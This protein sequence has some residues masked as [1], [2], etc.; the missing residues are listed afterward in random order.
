[1]AR[2]DEARWIQQAKGL[3]NSGL[4]GT[5]D[6]PPFAVS[7][8]TYFYGANSA[9]VR[10]YM[11]RTEQIYK[12]KAS[13]PTHQLFLHARGTVSNTVREL[14]NNLVGNIRATIEGDYLV[15]WSD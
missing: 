8:L 9:Q 13:G 5:H 3:L 4:E 6:L 12:D 11:L 10:A 1:M 7:M 15:I 2:Q 14:E